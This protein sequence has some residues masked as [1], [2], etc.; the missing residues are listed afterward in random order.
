[1]SGATVTLRRADD[2][3]LSYVETL[4]E[5]NNLPSRDVRS[6][7]DCFYLGYDGG[8]SVGIGGVETHGADGLL[9]SVV[10]ERSAREAGYGTAMCEALEAEA[11]STGVETLYLLTTTARGFFADRGYVE[12]ER[13]TAPAA[14]RRTAEFDDLCPST[15]TC[16]KKSL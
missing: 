5:K 7:T 9:R 1:M 15:A 14:I 10:V 11:R 3:D 12:T 8:R 2:G 6:K 13:A 16:M 4:L